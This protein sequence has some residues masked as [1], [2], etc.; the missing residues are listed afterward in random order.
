METTSQMHFGANL[1]AN[2][3]AI[4]N[5]PASEQQIRT[6]FPS[7]GRLFVS[8]LDKNCAANSSICSD[9]SDNDI[10]CYRYQNEIKSGAKLMV[11]EGQTAVLVSHGEVSGISTRRRA[12]CVRARPLCR[13]PL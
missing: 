7:I 5:A 3:R 9:P 8:L 11:L 6:S 10:P 2:C 12:R 1:N 13:F 4:A